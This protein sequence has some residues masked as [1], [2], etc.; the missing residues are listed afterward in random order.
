MNRR[1]ALAATAGALAFPAA[2]QAH[3][4][5]HPNVLPSGA[6][7]TLVLRVPNEEDKASTTSVRIQVPPGFLDVSADPPPGWKFSTKT[8]KPVKTDE[9]TLTTE[10]S[11]ADFTGGS[12]PP[13]DF[14]QFPMSVV[15]PG[16]A[17]QQLTFK[18]LQGYSNGKVVRWI[19]APD[20]DSPAPWIDVSAK[21]G[22]LRDVA[23]SEAGPP[24]KVAASATPVSR[25][26]GVVVQKESSGASKGLGIAALV[27]GVLAL[28]AALAA[29]AT[30][31]RPAVTP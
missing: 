21:G 20:T 5:L 8:R 14:A 30:R 17:G 4:S 24:A 3:V 16:H 26:T 12:I 15:I 6:N 22:D 18:T 13:G 23:G 9:G 2:A 1:A 29:L 7:A 10:V 27:V 19:G 31:R 11:E 28:S 25:T